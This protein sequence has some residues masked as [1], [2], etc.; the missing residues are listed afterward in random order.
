[1][2]RP[3]VSVIVPVYNVS[4]YLRPCLD[5]LV[6]QTLTTIE[7]ICVDDGSTDDSL[8]ILQAYAEGDNRIKIIQQQ[9]QYAGI[10][11]NNGM[12][13]AQGEYLYFMDADDLCDAT[14]LEKSYQKAKQYQADIVL[15]SYQHL[16][17]KDGNYE[18]RDVVNALEVPELESIEV[19]NKHSLPEALYQVIRPHPWDKL[20][21]ADFVRASG[22]V[23]Q[24]ERSCND[25]Y[26]VLTLMALADKIAYLPEKLYYY[27]VDAQ[28]SLQKT[29]SKSPL[30]FIRA[31]QSVYDEL[32]KRG[33]YSIVEKSY[34]NRA[35]LGIDYDYSTTED[36]LA[37]AEV[38]KELV[39]SFFPR[40]GLLNHDKSYYPNIELFVKACRIGADFYESL[41]NSGN[42]LVSE[43][44]LK[45]EQDLKACWARRGELWKLLQEANAGRKKNW[46]A[47]MEA[48]AGRKRNWDALQE[49][50][51]ITKQ[52]REEIAELKKQL[53]KLKQE[54]EALKR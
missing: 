2:Q 20:F 12:K 3:L 43:K 5:S 21:R 38:R 49:Q 30:S 29:K 47:L 36:E 11:R 9:N 32:N 7:I 23:F 13:M 37:R 42:E 1:M 17:G 48:N 53:A 8:A 34:I 44:L 39:C 31:Y 50:R 52:Q 25:V 26:F 35:L 54:S 19:F 18:Y 22:I 33:I 14:M 27:R 46:D 6:A 24:G 51:L 15:F 4:A 41:G 10:A 40:T 28:G 45:L 16:V